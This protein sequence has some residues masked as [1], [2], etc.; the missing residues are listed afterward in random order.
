V[1]EQPVPVEHCALQAGEVGIFEIRI[2]QSRAASGQAVTVEVG[3]R[4][5]NV[6][7]L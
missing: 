2:P 7:R 5:S 1:G 3:G 6:L 4:R